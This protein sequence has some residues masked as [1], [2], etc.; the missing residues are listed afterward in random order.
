[1]QHNAFAMSIAF[2]WLPIA[3][4]VIGLLVCLVAGVRARSLG[5]LLFAVYFAYNLS[6]LVIG[7]IQYAREAAEASHF[8]SQK[9]GPNLWT[10]PVVHV[11]YASADAARL[12]VQALLVLTAVLIAR[13]LAPRRPG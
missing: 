4:D 1:M 11:H 6:V 12:F 10:A 5:L 3:L 8:I 9:L 13:Q 2:W 7:A